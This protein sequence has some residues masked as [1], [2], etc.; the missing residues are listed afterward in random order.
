MKIEQSE[1]EQ[2][3]RESERLRILTAIQELQDSKWR[4][5]A[6]NEVCSEVKRIITN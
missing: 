6:V 2:A 3:I 5:W 1:L 4:E